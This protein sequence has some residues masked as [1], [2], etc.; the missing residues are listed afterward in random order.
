MS[1]Y[2]SAGTLTGEGE[3]HEQWVLCP[4]TP[5]H[6]SASSGRARSRT[7]QKVPPPSAWKSLPL[8]GSMHFFPQAKEQHFS[9]PPQSASLLHKSGTLALQLTL[10]L[11]H[12]P[13]FSATKTWLNSHPLRVSGLL[14]WPRGIGKLSQP[15]PLPLIFNI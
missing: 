1:M 8:Y 11:R 9:N 14:P 3:K 7:P 5:G 13:G 10:S 6:C 12:S 15:C 2:L 4:A